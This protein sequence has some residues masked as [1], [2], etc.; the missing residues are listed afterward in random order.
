MP[1]IHATHASTDV[2]NR[3]KAYQG[4]P[5]GNSP[6]RTS[7]RPHSD[8]C[9][10]LVN[11]FDA[12]N[13]HYKRQLLEQTVIDD[14]TFYRDTIL[15]PLEHLLESSCTF[16]DLPDKFLSTDHKL[17]DP[18]HALLQ[19]MIAAT[20]QDHMVQDILSKYDDYIN[21][22]TSY[23]DSRFVG[24]GT[25]TP[26]ELIDNVPEAVNPV[27]TRLAYI[28][29]PDGDS[30]QLDLVWKFEV[31]MKDNWYEAA[32]SAHAPHKII[33]VVDWA[34]DAYA[35]IPRKERGLATYNIF[36]WG[37]NDPSE[38]DR[39]IETE[40]NDKL[41][42]PLGWHSLPIANDPY[43]GD[44]RFAYGSSIRNTTVTWGNNVFAHE[45]W[46]GHNGYIANYRPDG[47]ED[48]KFHYAYN[49]K[50]TPSEDALEEARKYV[51]T[52][53]TQLFYTSNL[54]HDLYYRYVLP[55]S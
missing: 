39:T 44:E 27:K 46:D 10:Q 37:I 41:A 29:V 5:P 34:S 20:P 26:V 9:S 55:F 32:V 2:I 8:Y 54:V 30:T 28:Q 53:I 14:L 13:A 42:S 25:H 40:Y 43:S 7:A 11:E 19:F 49:P 50:S 38:G 1:Q 21:E 18:R 22:M 36:K 51:N 6:V 48:L 4:P 35:P 16:T 52:S 12:R 31:E 33:S 23:M 17:E 3:I 45:N 47:G 15:R 24:D